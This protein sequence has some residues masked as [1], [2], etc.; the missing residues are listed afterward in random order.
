MTVLK[1]RM[2][3]MGPRKVVK[4]TA[5]SEMKQLYRGR[6]ENT[7]NHLHSNYE[8]CIHVLYCPFSNSQSLDFS[9]RL[10]YNKISA[11]SIREVYNHRNHHRNNRCHWG[12]RRRIEDAICSKVSLWSSSKSGHIQF[13]SSYPS[14]TSLVPRP[15]ASLPSL[16]VRLTIPLPY[17]RLI[18]KL[19]KQQ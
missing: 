6:R 17:C 19:E 10:A 7:I 2:T 14:S 5:G 12:K 18:W 11:D 16:A 3:K 4:N 9:C 8:C 15:S 1:S 13:T